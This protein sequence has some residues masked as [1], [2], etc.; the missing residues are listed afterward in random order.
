MSMPI[1]PPFAV[2]A[3][4][5][6]SQYATGTYT[7]G[8]SQVFSHL[9][10]PPSAGVAAETAADDAAE[11][12]G[13]TAYSSRSEVQ[14]ITIEGAPTGGTFTLTWGDDTTDPLAYN[15]TALQVQTA[16]RALQYVPLAY[17]GTT[18]VQTVTITGT[19]TGGTFTLTYSGQTTSALNWNATANQV[20]TALRAL[21]NIPDTDLTVTGGPGPGTAFQVA[22]TGTLANTDVAQMTATPSLTGGTTP[23]VTVTTGTAGVAASQN[24]TVTGSNGGPYSVNFTGKL[25]NLNVAEIVANGEDLTGDGDEDVTVETT[26]GGRGAFVNGA[27]QLAHQQGDTMRDFYDSASGNHF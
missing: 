12:L 1:I 19:P 16:L 25:A 17:G 2:K 15:A 22:F 13:F 24:V 23:S 6:N 27:I 14:V 18:E 5:Q 9:V 7:Q 11:A 20:Q 3:S 21:S 26:T 8:G 4:Y 10:T